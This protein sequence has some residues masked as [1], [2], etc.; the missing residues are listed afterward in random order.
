MS[1]RFDF[2]A[3]NLSSFDQEG[4]VSFYRKRVMDLAFGA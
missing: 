4:V 1:R 3:E 2:C